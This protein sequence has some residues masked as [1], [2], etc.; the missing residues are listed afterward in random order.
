MKPKRPQEVVQNDL[1]KTRLD[2]FLNPKHELY[3]LASKIDWAR[4]DEEFGPFFEAEQGAPA[5]STR[6]IAG[7]HYLKH[8]EGLSDEAV[9]KRWVENGYWQYFCGETFFQHEVPCHPTSLTKWRQ[10][11]G[12]AGCEWLLLLTIEAGVATRTVKKR[13]FQSVTVD[14]TVQEKAVGFPT[15]GKLYEKCRREL[16]KLAGQHGL[17]LRQNYNKKA[18]LLLVQSHRYSSCQ[19]NEA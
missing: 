6:L 2:E 11:I 17:P 9:V 15:D 18:P 19:A 12:E 14:T 16:V 1:F 10:R 5:L 13:D 7:L 8:A 3:R 4:L